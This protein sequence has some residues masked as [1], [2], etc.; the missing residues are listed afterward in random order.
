[1]AP[2][3]LARVLAARRRR[4]LVAIFDLDGTLAPIA[5]RPEA[6][7]VPIATRRAIARLA[8]RSDT[9]VGVVSGRPLAQVTARI[10]HPRIW[11]AGLHGAVRR[12]PNG[13][14][15]HANG[16]DV[17]TAKTA[18]VLARRLVLAL[19]AVPGV[20]IERKGPIVAVHLRGVAPRLHRSVYAAVVGA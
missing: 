11:M 5:A 8:G 7:R 14:V 9:L 1:M 16:L 3:D 18:D 6:A 20:R 15:V 2:L 4:G 10:D 17:H 13:R 12:A 19:S